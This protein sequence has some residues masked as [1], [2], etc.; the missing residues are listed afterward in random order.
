MLPRLPQIFPA[1]RLVALLPVPAAEKAAFIAQK[2]HFLFQFL[3]QCF[4]VRKIRIQS[5]IR[6][7]VGKFRPFQ[8]R[9]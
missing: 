5:E 4:Q 6:D 7:N 1:H 2:F 3:G 8:F 9:F